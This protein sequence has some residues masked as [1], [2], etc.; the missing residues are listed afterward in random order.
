MQICVVHPSLL[1]LSSLTYVL[2][3][4]NL[5]SESLRWLRWRCRKTALDL[6]WHMHAHKTPSE[7]CLQ[8]VKYDHVTARYR[9]IP[10]AK[11]QKRAFY[12]RRPQLPPHRANRVCAASGGLFSGLKK[13]LQGKEEPQQAGDT[14]EFPPC[15]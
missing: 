14:V 2:L 7:P 10:L 5:L 3:Y 6:Q 15:R 4:V 13:A 8:S 9:S 1:L 12:L 11:H